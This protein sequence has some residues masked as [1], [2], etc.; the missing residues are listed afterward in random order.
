MFVNQSLVRFLE[1]PSAPNPIGIETNDEGLF[2]A[3]GKIPNQRFFRKL[4][5]LMQ[6]FK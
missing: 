3:K 6:I 1:N 5:N 2:L 4:D